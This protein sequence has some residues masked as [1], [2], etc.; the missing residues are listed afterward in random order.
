[1]STLQIPRQEYKRRRNERR[2]RSKAQRKAEYKRLCE[3]RLERIAELRKLWA[4][5]PPQPGDLLDEDAA[6]LWAGGTKPIDPSTLRR[7][8]SPPIKVGAHAVRWPFE[9]LQADIVHM[10]VGR[11]SETFSNNLET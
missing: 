3:R 11:T 10:N 4:E 2:K 1:V 9:N 8:Y 6:C 5:I 7:R